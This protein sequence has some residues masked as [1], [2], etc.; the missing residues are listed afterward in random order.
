M[1]QDHTARNSNAAKGSGVAANPAEADAA[2]VLDE[3][4]NSAAKPF[5]YLLSSVVIAAGGYLLYAMLHG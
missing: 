4:L 2:L 3:E 1:R 5:L